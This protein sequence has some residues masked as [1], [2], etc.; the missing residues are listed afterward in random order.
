MQ[1][2]LSGKVNVIEGLS[3]L[4]WEVKVDNKKKD[5]VEDESSKIVIKDVN[6]TDSK[7]NVKSETKTE[8]SDFEDEDNEDLA[9]VMVKLE[10]DNNNVDTYDFYEYAEDS[11]GKPEAQNTSIHKEKSDNIHKAKN[12][13]RDNDEYTNAESMHDFPDNFDIDDETTHKLIDTMLE[14]FLESTTR[15]KNKNQ[16]SRYACN[17]C[18]KKFTSEN[19]LA[20][21]KKMSHKVSFA[22][23]V[24][25]K[26]FNKINTL[27]IHEQVHTKSSQTTFS[28]NI[29]GDTYYD[30]K[31]V[32]L[33]LRDA[34]GY[35]PE[36]SLVF[37]KCN[38][39]GK[40]FKSKA[41]YHAH[42]KEHASGYS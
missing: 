20:H 30:S 11:E 18:D 28:C 36:D 34:H 8:F 3:T 25:G 37:K 29:C 41:S 2:V 7:S 39:C 4:K 1:N 26:V 24:C 31:S 17:K 14:T 16:V 21:H 27:K 35:K 12:Q 38:V 23:K 40:C 32:H 13:L 9:K 6:N 10:K 22:C 19:Q 33:H 5:Y 15:K 42:Q